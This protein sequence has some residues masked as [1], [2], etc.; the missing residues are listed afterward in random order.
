MSF[1]KKHHLVMKLLSLLIAIVLWVVVINA[2]NPKKTMEFQDL[3][4]E[5]LEQDTLL[6]QYGLVVSEIET[7]E[8]TVKVAGNFKTLGNVSADNIKVRAD[9]SDYTT[10]GTYRLSYDVSAP[11]G[12]TVE[13]RTP[14]RIPSLL[15]RSWK[16]SSRYRCSMRA[17]CPP[18]SA[19]A[20]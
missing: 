19:S 5:L 15:S 13:S 14:E 8:V 18:G 10:P 3:P 16:K 7:E 6:S 17:C 9:L 12:I 1:I 20:R 2:D 4:V 11:I